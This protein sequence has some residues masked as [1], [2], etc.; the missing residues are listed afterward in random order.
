MIYACPIW[1]FAEEN[2]LMKLQ[3]LQNRFLRAIC[4]LDRRS[5]VRDFHLS[6]KIP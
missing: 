2:Y 3:R 6:F 1:E 5:P 4:N